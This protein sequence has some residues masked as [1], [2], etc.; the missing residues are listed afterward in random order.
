VFHS[1][2]DIFHG[3]EL[4]IPIFLAQLKEILSKK[5]DFGEMDRF[6]LFLQ[7]CRDFE[8]QTPPLS[9]PA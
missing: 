5:W 4:A 2:K 3:Y 1:P 6:L 9:L 8:K 7:R